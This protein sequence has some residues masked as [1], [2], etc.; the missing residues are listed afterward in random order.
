MLR[1]CI[2][3]DL[4]KETCHL[5][6]DIISPSMDRISTGRLSITPGSKRPEILGIAHRIASVAVKRETSLV[7]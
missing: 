7:I 6:V 3:P 5:R 1:Q 4:T 2:M